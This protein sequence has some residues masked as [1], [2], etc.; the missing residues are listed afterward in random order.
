MYHVG[1]I[2]NRKVTFSYRETRKRKEPKILLSADL[3]AVKRL[4]LF[5]LRSSQGAGIML[6]VQRRE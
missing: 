4:L 5:S 1:D 3:N 2:M 6:V